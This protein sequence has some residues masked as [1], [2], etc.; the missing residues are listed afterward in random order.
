[1]II[2]LTI[3]PAVDRNIEADRLVFEDRAYILA[4]SDSPGGRGIIASRVLHSFGAKT[5]AI[6]VSGGKNGALLEKLLA[7]AGYPILRAKCLHRAKDRNLILP[8]GCA[9]GFC[10]RVHAGA[11]LR[12]P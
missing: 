8:A 10:W 4:Q 12:I 3:N 6:V 11:Y 7:R 9:S 2:T 5:L 1:M